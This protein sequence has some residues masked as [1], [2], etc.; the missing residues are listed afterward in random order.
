M[1]FR[2]FGNTRLAA[3]GTL[4]KRDRIIQCRGGGIPEPGHFLELVGAGLLAAMAGSLSSLVAQLMGCHEAEIVSHTFLV[5]ASLLGMQ[6]ALSPTSRF[7][8]KTC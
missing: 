7:N 3:V 6:P 1:V 8:R 4:F 5:C 2:T